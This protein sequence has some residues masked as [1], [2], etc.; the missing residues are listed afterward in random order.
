MTP[1][2]WLGTLQTS[3]K[4]E[5]YSS[6]NLALSLSYG[7]LACH[8]TAAS[9]KG[10]FNTDGNAIALSTA[11]QSFK[12]DKGATNSHG[13]AKSARLTATWQVTTRLPG[14]GEE[15]PVILAANS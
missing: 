8:Y 6:P 11:N 5:L 13:C 4:S 12:L 15:F 1:G 9:L 3:G 10:N 2:R 14:S 7:G